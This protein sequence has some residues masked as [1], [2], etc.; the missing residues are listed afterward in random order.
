[1]GGAEALRWR[2]EALRTDEQEVKKDFETLLRGQVPDG[3][4]IKTNHFVGLTDNTTAL[5]VVMDVNG[6]LGTQTGKRVFL[7]SAFFEAREKPLFAAGKRENPVDMH[8]PYVA[9]D[10]V[11]LVLAPGLAIESLP[12]GTSIRFR[13]WPFTRRTTAT[14]EARTTRNG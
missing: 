6:S 4:E 14:R 2:Q 5:L 9:Q 11:D 3:V 7:P 13:K 12:K 8:Y 10:K 1:M